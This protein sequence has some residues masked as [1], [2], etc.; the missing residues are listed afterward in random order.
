MRSARRSVFA[1]GI[2]IL[3][4][5]ASILLGYVT[6]LMWIRWERYCYPTDFSEDVAFCAEQYD[7]DEAVI[8][9]M[10]KVLSD[11]ES[12]RV[13]DDGRIGLMQLS[14]DTFRELTEKHLNEGLDSGLLYEPST[15]IR[16]GCY[17]LLYLT[18]RFDSWDATYAAYLCGEETVDIWYGEWKQS[19]STES[20]EF[21]IPDEKIRKTVDKIQRTVEKYKKLYYEKGDVKS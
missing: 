16:Y 14:A 10:I 9:A 5:A 3:L 18:T 13:S 8:Y 11:F 1:S 4:L 7:L 19:A 2:A 6:D 21:D 12:N 17:Y 20:T 15:N